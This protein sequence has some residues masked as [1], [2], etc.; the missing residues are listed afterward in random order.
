MSLPFLVA[1]GTLM[2]PFGQLESLGLRSSLAFRSE[3]QFRGELYDLGAFPGAVPGASLLHGE[4]F[5]LEAPDAL[6]VLDNYEGYMPDREEDSLFVRRKVSLLR[7]TTTRAWVYWYNGDPSDY[8]KVSSGNW[9][10][11]QAP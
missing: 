10:A 8:P 1:Y 4:L 6:S 5:R 11:Y 7:P 2:R 9:A 3:C